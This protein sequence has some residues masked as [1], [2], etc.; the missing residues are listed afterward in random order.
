[1]ARTRLK[2]VQKAMRTRIVESRELVKSDRLLFSAL[3]LAFLKLLG[4]YTEIKIK[5]PISH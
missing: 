2:R 5:Q 1:M 4:R 3:S